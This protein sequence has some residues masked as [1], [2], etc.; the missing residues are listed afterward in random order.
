MMSEKV[1]MRLWYL[2]S[3]PCINEFMPKWINARQAPD[4]WEKWSLPIG[5][6]YM[7]A[8]VF[9]RTDVERIQITENSLCNPGKGGGLNN[10]AEVMIRLGHT[11]VENYVR[12]LNL[13]DGMARVRY[14][15]EGVTYTREVFV[16]YPDRVMVIQLTASAQGKLSFT[17]E[18]RIPF[19]KQSDEGYSKSGEVYSE[20]NLITLRGEMEYYAIQFEGQFLIQTEDGV[21]TAHDG[22]LDV[23]SATSVT[24]IAA[25]GTNYRMESRVFTEY[26]PKKKLTPYPHPHEVVKG[27]IENAA[28]KGFDELRKRH[29]ED[30]CALF[31]RVSLSLGTD[32]Y[33]IPT[34]QLLERYKQGEKLPYLEAL[35]Y[36]FG[37]Y[38][39]ISSS[40]PG[41]LPANLQGVWNCYDESPWGSGYWHNINV[42]MN[43]WP[44]FVANLAETFTAYADYTDAYMAQA[45]EMAD[46][47]IKAFFPEKLEAPGKNGWII[48]TAAYPYTITNA[49]GGTI[50]NPT[51]GHS[52]PGTGAFTSIL[53]WE[54][55]DYTRDQE[56]F[57]KAFPILKSMSH[58]LAKTVTE[59]DGKLL[60]KY[61]ASPEQLTEGK[62]RTNGHYY[63]TVGCAFDQQ[64]IYENHYDLIRAAEIL[65]LQDDPDVVT[66]R[67]QIEKLDPVQVGI[68][69]Q[70][71]EYRE[72][73]AYGEI[74]E[75]AHRH[76]SHLVGLY[77]GS[78]IN[79]N[80]PAWMEAAR[81]TLNL[82]GDRSTGWAMAHRLNA[83]ARALDGNRAYTLYRTL[84][85]RG[86]FPNLWDAHPPFQIDGNFGGT[87]G[88]SEMLVQSQ[89]G[90]IDVLPALPDAW[91]QGSFKGLVAR[92]NFV[93]DAK[94]H[95]GKAEEVCV[96]ARIG[97]EMRIRCDKLA[98]AALF[99][100]N[101][102]RLAAADGTGE[103]QYHMRPEERVYLRPVK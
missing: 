25:V 85:S 23:C 2:E 41:A 32:G 15:A 5:N 1:P 65:G 83:W 50:E 88:V 87:S 92:G 76:I 38:L 35:Y 46:D 51:I 27:L 63:H 64:M 55:Y 96:T 66:A 94:W 53:F 21:V 36:Q 82:R 93:V 69:G 99:D 20:G 30:Y 78:C 4:G 19:I 61:S 68:S 7:G 39:L 62:W 42:Q 10:F 3:A 26:D 73:K 40:R 97:G 101:G 13:D 33:D 80:T 28:E 77:P 48:G 11:K 17:L 54:W 9:G 70:I 79:R 8:N 18:P 12:E 91:A 49:M 57:K 86:T 72:E 24:I 58:F 31:S 60:A 81:T 90:F 59:V 102:E 47:Y 75:W 34:D 98:G 71:K 103:F 22:M 43:Y 67:E 6:G 14:D 84:L 56:V 95:D 44:A 52:G 100:E 45:E 74:G 89:A 29:Q 16:S 37:R